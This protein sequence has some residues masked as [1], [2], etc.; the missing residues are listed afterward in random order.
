MSVG[1]LG[2]DSPDGAENGNVSS[3]AEDEAQLS[4]DEDEASNHTVPDSS[5]AH[6]AHRM[7][8]VV[9]LVL[10]C[11]YWLASAA[12]NTELSIALLTLLA[13]ALLTIAPSVDR[14]PECRRGR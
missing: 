7:L 13:I 11:L 9:M 1:Q 10:Y 5:L 4:G 3:E 8:C 14:D 6:S 12:L 2:V